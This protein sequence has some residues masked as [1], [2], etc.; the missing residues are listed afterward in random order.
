M[1]DNESI[2]SLKETCALKRV[3]LS[4]KVVGT[5]DISL[6]LLEAISAISR[7]SLFENG[8]FSENAVSAINGGAQ[9]PDLIV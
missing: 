2:K 3:S 7:K 1:T 8:V 6:K 4:P 9:I 5:K